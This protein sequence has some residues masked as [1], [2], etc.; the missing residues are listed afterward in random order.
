VIEKAP[1]TN[2][3]FAHHLFNSFIELICRAYI[4]MTR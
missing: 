1:I 3:L 2:T 4:Q